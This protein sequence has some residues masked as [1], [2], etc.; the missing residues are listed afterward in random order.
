LSAIASAHTHS[1]DGNKGILLHLRRDHEGIDS[2]TR[3]HILEGSHGLE[4]REEFPEI[5]PE[6]EPRPA[7][8]G[9]HITRDQHGCAYCPY[10]AVEKV[11]KAHV[12][13]K[14]PDKRVKTRSG[15]ATQVLNTGFCKTQFR[16]VELPDDEPPSTPSS[17]LTPPPP[18]QRPPP[19]TQR[20]MAAKTLSDL[21][22]DFDPKDYRAV[23]LPNPRMIAPWLLC[24]GWHEHLHPYREN[25]EEL[26]QLVSLPSDEEF[27]ILHE[28]VASYF[29]TATNLI[30]KT[31]EVVLQRLNSADPDKKWV[32]DIY[33]AASLLI[34]L[35][36]DQQHTTTCLPPRR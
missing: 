15:V 2:A 8:S 23:D 19:L 11:V 17:E 18:T 28:A 21:V 33:K 20:S 34:D 30:K 36:R 7:F 24:N 32:L 10:V 31:N 27:P 35:Q 26:R 14:H 25:D 16:V 5:K 9:V 6:M 29:W 1:H 12:K 4:I 13:S 22:E 3:Q